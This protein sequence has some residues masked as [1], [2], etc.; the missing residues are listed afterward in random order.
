VRPAGPGSN[1]A[2]TL[3]PDS[4]A[5][6]PGPACYG[7]GGD[8]ATLTDAFV[9]AGLVNPEYFLGG[10]KPLDR[11]LAREAIQKQ[12]GD[13]LHLS[14]DEACGAIIDRAFQLVGDVICEA[15]AELK[16]DLSKHTLFAYGGNGG[17]FACGVAERAGLESVYF[18]SLGPVFSAF[19]SSVSDIS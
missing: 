1:P 5:S 4:M 12:V 9:S 11:E 17:L 10:S 13:P 16:K 8:Q 7:L 2:V 19:G 15:R 14:I 3:G 18:F 6:F